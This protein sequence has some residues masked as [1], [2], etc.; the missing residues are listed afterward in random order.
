M[1][2]LTAYLLF[3]LI[4][5]TS[6]LS[7][8][9]L[10]SEINSEIL[11]DDG[12]WKYR[13]SDD[14]NAEITGYF[15]KEKNISIPE[16]IGEYTVT[17]IGSAAFY[18]SDIEKITFPSS[19]DSI[20]WWAFYGCKKLS[21]V[22]LNDGL[23]IIEYGAFMNCHNLKEIS[24]P[25]TVYS[26]GEDAFGVSCS[27]SKDIKDHYSKKSISKQS[28]A[29]NK[30]FIISGYEGTFS[31]KYASLHNLVFV[32]SL[33]VNFCDA[34]LNGTVDNNDIIL[35]KK[36]IDGKA[37]LS[38]SQKRNS[39]VD[40]D[41]NVTVFDIELI[42]KYVMNEISLSELPV[43]ENIEEKTD[44]LYGKTMY[45]DGDS[46]AKGTGTN[47]LG[48][49][50]YSYCN[51]ITDTYN[52]TSVNKSVAG[53][54]I[55][56]Q[57]N[58]TSPDNKSILE[59]VREMKGNYDIVLLEGGFN[60][61]FQKIEIGE[62]TDINDK[63]GNYNEYTTAGALE[64]ICYF[65][66]EN[67]ADSVKLFVLCHTRNA[68]PDQYK[69]WNIITEVL[70]KWNI[71]Y[72]DIS[73]ETDFCDINDEISTQYFMYNKDKKKGD[74]IHP[75]EYAARKI[76]GPVIADK[77]NKLFCDDID[78]SFGDKN[79][80]L[81]LGEGFYQSPIISEEYDGYLSRW[82]SDNPNVATVNSNGEIVAR[83]MGKTTIRYCTNDGKTSCYS[84][85]VKF[86][87]MDL[88]LDSTKLNL[89]CGESHTVSTS[90]LNGTTAYHISF[91]S[92]DSSVAEVSPDS[93][94][95]TAV[96]I[97][98]AVITCRTPSGVVA[99]CTVTVQ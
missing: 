78:V 79:I 52:M 15:G 38:D 4:I 31:Q 88:V 17:S 97:G 72:V 76:Y 62:V 45:C 27:T 77:L 48:S 70:N 33:A 73:S 74:G 24:L 23:N 26:I 53:T 93:G 85:T 84:V 83:G 51:Y 13:V 58:K 2:K 68:N 42:E 95:I 3:V 10:S 14:N 96:S 12:V 21:F 11:A 7:A 92:S 89:K 64:S 22:E 28:Y 32:S 82:S 35:I 44:F 56:K 50:F 6:C 37:K 60:D 49:D 75:L 5:F 34:D 61:L 54:T 9:A 40:G 87:A 1:K 29:Y 66:N 94:V 57:K 43:A 25:Y 18:N 80:E 91:T 39:D 86:M 65:L 36:Y 69:Y 81:G 8:D 67:Y 98:K 20:G 30:N 59:R 99:Q 71:D 46:V 90:F 47:I 19:V 41:A 63:S 16:K 55:A